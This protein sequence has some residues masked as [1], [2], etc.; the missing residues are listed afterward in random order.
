[1]CSTSRASHLYSTSQKT[2][3]P[4]SLLGLMAKIKCSICS[5]QFNIWYAGHR[6]AHIL[7][8]FLAFGQGSGVYL[9][10]T[11]GCLGIAL[12]S[13]AAHIFI[14]ELKK[15]RPR[16]TVIMTFD[17]YSSRL[18]RQFLQWLCWQAFRRSPYQILGQRT[19]LEKETRI[20][21]V[22][23]ILPFYLQIGS[24]GVCLCSVLER[25]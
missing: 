16:K 19:G 7:I 17:S 25:L 3:H 8:W 10:L 1:M 9:T 13:S 15:V 2:L 4:V 12:Q 23:N 18:S 14:I 5:Y 21:Y 22:T 6:P 20:L 11:T 24:F